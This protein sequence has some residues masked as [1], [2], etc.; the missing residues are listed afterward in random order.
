MNSVFPYVEDAAEPFRLKVVKA[1]SVALKQITPANGFHYDMSDHPSGQTKVFRGRAIFGQDTEPP[2]ITI[3]ED[4]K[5]EDGHMASR[6]GKSFTYD[7]DLMIQG[8]VER[9]MDNPTDRA[10]FLMDDVRRRLTILREDENHPDR[11]FRFGSKLN[12]V[13]G[14]EFNRGL[15]RPADEMSDTAYF[16]MQCCL[17]VVETPT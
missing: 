1:M 2:F 17:S 5:L 6:A 14:L 12:T 13:T 3:L 7:L 15:V 10:Y 9:S 4:P 11:V 8:F 16:W